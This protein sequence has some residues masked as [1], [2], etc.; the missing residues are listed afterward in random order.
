MIK[1]EKTMSG[2]AVLTKERIKRTAEKMFIE[3]GY[4]ATTLRDITAKAG[5]TTG[6]FYKH[7][8]SKEEILISIFNDGFTKQWEKFYELKEDITPIT[9]AKIIGEINN[10]L[11]DAFGTEL[12]K[13]YCTA[14][15]EMGNSG[16]LWKIL[17]SEKYSR[18]EQV[19][20]ENLVSRYS[21]KYSWDQ[22]DDIIA[23]ID[24]GV[25]LDWIIKQG[26][27]NLGKETN[28]MLLMIFEVIF[29]K[30]DWK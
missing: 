30:W 11:A 4:V 21:T 7:Y 27:Y 25:I 17:D 3:K 22:V 10:G 12:L 16:S 20:L 8:G 2:K 19:L 18:Y 1:M 29:D 23:K 24:R 26:S 28:E 14:Q 15:L 13:V 6:A 5:V 9:Y